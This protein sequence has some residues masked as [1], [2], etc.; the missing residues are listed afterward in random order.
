VLVLH[1][2]WY[3]YDNTYYQSVADLEG[4]PSP[5]HPFSP[6]NYQ[7]TVVKFRIWYQKWVYVLL[8]H[9]SFPNLLDPLL[10]IKNSFLHFYKGCFYCCQYL[11][12]SYSWSGIY[13]K[14]CAGGLDQTFFSH[15]YS[16][17]HFILVCTK[18]Y[19]GQRRSPFPLVCLG[20]FFSLSFCLSSKILPKNPPL[21]YKNSSDWTSTGPHPH[22]M[23]FYY[24]LNH[25]PSGMGLV[26]LLIKPSFPTPDRRIY[27]ASS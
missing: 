22:P 17:L 24:Y 3:D 8:I 25:L 4:G 2:I 18:T 9:T 5:P 6:K 11:S 15:L 26:L 20:F 19:Q 21:I 27:V 23:Y 10:S 16:V 13:F 12:L 1:C 7:I 14:A